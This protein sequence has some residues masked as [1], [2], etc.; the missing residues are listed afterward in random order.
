MGVA[1]N[2]HSTT[3][4]ATLHNLKPTTELILPPKNKYKGA[5]NEL[6]ITNRYHTS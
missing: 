6:D 3:Q 1:N 5:F 2:E 4:Y